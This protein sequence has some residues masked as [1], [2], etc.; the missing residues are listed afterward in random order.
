MLTIIVVML[1]ARLTEVE[2]TI[3]VAVL[4][5]TTTL[6]GSRRIIRVFYI[7]IALNMGMMLTIV[8]IIA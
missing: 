3:A 4:K 7:W 8:C 5:R 6:F 1:K 2:R